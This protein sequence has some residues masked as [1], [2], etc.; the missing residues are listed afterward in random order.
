M[1][2]YLEA[3]RPHLFAHRGASGEAPENTM[4]AFERALGYGIRFL[5]M[6]CHATRDGKIVICHDALLDRTTDAT[7]PLCARSFAELREVD[8]GYRFSPDGGQSFP[9]RGKGV[10]IPLLLDVL[11]SFPEARINLEVK[12]ADPPIAAEVLRQV[13]EAGACDRVLLAAEHDG[14]MAVIRALDPDTATG[15]SLGDAVA[16][17]RAIQAGTLDDFEPG[18]DALQIPANFGPDPLVTEQSV[19]AA[20]RL[21]LAMHVWTINDPTEMHRLLEAGVDGVMSDFP[22]RLLEEARAHASGG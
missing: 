14:I 12:Q 10:R 2:P 5:E 11:S 1:H 15:S 16:F 13:S 7:G 17:F 19:S 8:A 6:D 9:F 4:P 21:G 3:P 20:R 18:G 22:G